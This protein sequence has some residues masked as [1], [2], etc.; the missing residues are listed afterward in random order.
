MMPTKAELITAK[1]FLKEA[2]ALVAD[3]QGILRSD[4]ATDRRLRAIG[5]ALLN[6]IER[7]T[8]LLEAQQS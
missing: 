5:Q 4:D 3:A 6:E 8:Q 2:V 7:V 1:R